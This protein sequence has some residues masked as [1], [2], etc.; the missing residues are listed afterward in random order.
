MAL[1]FLAPEWN[2][3]YK[4]IDQ[5]RRLE[6]SNP[7]LKERIDTYDKQIQ[8]LENDPGILTRLAEK[9]LGIDTHNENEA[10]PQP[11]NELLEIANRALSEVEK[12]DAPKTKLREYIERCADKKTR[13]GLF[14]SGAAL[15]MITF[16][17]FG[18]A[19]RKQTNTENAGDPEAPES[20][21]S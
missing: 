17:C 9:T 15:I 4:S 19:K 5:V 14:Y 6:A 20:P 12:T 1:S 3:N 2:E 10:F 21:A 8:T 7:K 16:I 18:A 11:S 13:K